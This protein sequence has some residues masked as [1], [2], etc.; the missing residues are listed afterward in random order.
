[1]DIQHIPKTFWHALSLAILIATVGLTYVAYRSS[2]VSIELANAKINLSSEVASSAIALNTAIEEVKKAKPETGMKYENIG[3]KR[4]LENEQPTN[5]EKKEETDNSIKSS[6]DQV[7]RLSSK[8]KNT[9]SLPPKLTFENFDKNI[10]S[11]QESLDKLES[12][13]KQIQ[14][15]K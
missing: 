2:T 8:G 6:S 1:M 3:I 5:I 9:T 15:L 4:N 11:A 10:I 14:Q 13:N 12:I 7:K